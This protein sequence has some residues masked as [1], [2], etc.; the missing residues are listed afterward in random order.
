MSFLIDCP[1]CGPRPSTDFR[2]G[3]ETRPVEDP[4]SSELDEIK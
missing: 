2:Y 4:S 3:G 1:N